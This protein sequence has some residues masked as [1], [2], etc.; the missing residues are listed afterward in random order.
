MKKTKKVNVKTLKTVK[1]ET[2]KTTQKADRIYG[3]IGMV[4]LFLVGVIFG[5]V[6]NGSD[7]VNRSAMSNAECEELVQ[8]IKYLIHTNQYDQL[9]IANAMYSENCVDRGFKR[10]E[11]KVEEK[12]LPDTTCGKI[13]NLLSG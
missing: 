2:R 5:Y 8:N 9:R 11:I 6:I 10:A 4:A 3:M 1:P 7:H 12:K 13:E